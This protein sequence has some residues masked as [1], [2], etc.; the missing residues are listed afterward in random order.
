[1]TSL[2]GPNGAGK[3]TLLNMLSGVIRPTHGKIY[4]MNKDIT[5]L[6]PHKIVKMGV[7]RGFQLLC[8]CSNL[9]TLD[10]VR[11]A[12]L[13][14]MGRIGR[15]FSPIDRDRE[16]YEKALETLKTFGL[17]KKRNLLARDL[18]HGDKKLLDVAMAFALEPK[19]ILLDEPTS[20]VSTSEKGKIMGTIEKVI[21]EKGITALIVEH[22]MD[23]V[24][25]YS[26]RILVMHEGR[27]I[28]DG[29]PEE[30]KSDKKI[31][32]ILLGVG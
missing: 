15:V 31:E 3:T 13:S 6:S 26:D 21:R 30:I 22:D 23:V 19:L 27:L 29:K 14:H 10:N 2:I 8:I 4:F 5:G 25:S 28:A 11:I 32:S 20:G 1:M 12:I 9:T 16:A 24:F 7:T 17:D 18:P